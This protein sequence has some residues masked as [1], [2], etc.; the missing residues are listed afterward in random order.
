MRVLPQ[1]LQD[2]FS[3]RSCP[4]SLRDNENKL[5]VPE[6]RTDYLKRSFSYDGAVPWNSLPTQ[7]RSAQSL[8]VFKGGLDNWLASADSHTAIM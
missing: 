7:R 2:L 6:P 4:Y 8:S 3:L 5:F 1:Y